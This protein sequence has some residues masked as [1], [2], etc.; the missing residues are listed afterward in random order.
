MQVYTPTKK[1]TVVGR[2]S[3]NGGRP[4]STLVSHPLYNPKFVDLCLLPFPPCPSFSNPFLP[5]PSRRYALTINVI[6][7]DREFCVYCG[8]AEERENKSKAE[9]HATRDGAHIIQRNRCMERRGF[10]MI[11]ISP[12]SMDFFSL[13]PGF[14]PRGFS[15]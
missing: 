2:M 14:L 12:C 9:K 1:P 7:R 6:S 15:R 10:N 8:V 13:L 5:L 4:P 11:N 3:T